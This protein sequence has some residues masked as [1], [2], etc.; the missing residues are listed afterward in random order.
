MFS[1]H[2][3]KM[4]FSFTIISNVAITTEKFVNNMGTKFFGNAVFK[5]KKATQI[6]IDWKITLMLHWGSILLKQLYNLDL[7]F[8]ENWPKKGGTIKKSFLGAVIKI[9]K[10]LDT[11]V[12]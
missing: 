2:H 4:A 3:I 6:I 10:S 8:K 1:G 9:Q 7:K 12:Y 11:L 5:S